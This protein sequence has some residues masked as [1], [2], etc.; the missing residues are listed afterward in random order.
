[1]ERG[2]AADALAVIALR[3]SIRRD[4]EHGRAVHAREALEL[5]ASWEDVAAAIVI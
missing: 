5:G 3:E 2:T 1:M 4:V